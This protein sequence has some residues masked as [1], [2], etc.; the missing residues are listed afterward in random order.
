MRVSNSE[1]A[2]GAK[3][4]QADPLHRLESVDTGTLSGSTISGTPGREQDFT[5]DVL[6]NWSA[7]LTKTNGTTDLSQTRTHNDAQLPH[8]NDG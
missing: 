6:G 1:H 8:P 7:Y 3:V 4:D 2:N 5:L